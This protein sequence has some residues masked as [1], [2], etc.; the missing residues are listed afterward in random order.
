MIALLDMTLLYF[1]SRTSYREVIVL[2][3]QDFVF[4]GCFNLVN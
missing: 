1:P 3:I 4:V 2:L